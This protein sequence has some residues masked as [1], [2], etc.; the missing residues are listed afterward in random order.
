MIISVVIANACP[1]FECSSKLTKTNSFSV[2]AECTLK[3]K[4]YRTKPLTIDRD[5][6]L[7]KGRVPLQAS[8]HMIEMGLRY[9]ISIANFV[10]TLERQTF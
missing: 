6:D 3:L 7:Q 1:G 2:G 4:Y 9:L 8:L 10:Q 5:F